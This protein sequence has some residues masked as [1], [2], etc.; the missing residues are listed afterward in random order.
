MAAEYDPKTCALG[1]KIKS[2]IKRKGIKQAEFAKVLGLTPSRL[3]NY[4]TGA[5]L[6]DIF[7][8]SQI[9]GA[10]G[11]SLDNLLG[12]ERGG[13]FPVRYTMTVYENGYVKLTPQP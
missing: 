13:V 6:P 1:A 12:L 3:S 5:R 4:I 7:I 8:L 2:E 10:L 9:A 11:M